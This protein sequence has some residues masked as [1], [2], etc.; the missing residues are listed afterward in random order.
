MIELKLVWKKGKEDVMGAKY[1][2]ESNKT[3]IDINN[4]PKY[5]YVEISLQFITKIHRQH[6]RTSQCG[7]IFPVQQTPRGKGFL[8]S[9]TWEGGYA[10]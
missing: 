9:V 8:H 3:I 1:S 4:K 2:E 6:N 7:Q 10:G 5:I